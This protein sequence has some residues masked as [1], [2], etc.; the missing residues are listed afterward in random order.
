MLKNNILI[1]IRH[2]KRNK[3]F[4]LINIFGLALSMVACLQIF[5]YVS[6]EK[7]YD[8]YHEGA[9]RVY[10]IYRVAEGE[11]PDDGVASL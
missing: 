9:D 3:L 11:A 7:S 6:F 5:K 1:A 4:S 2:L 10:R 8:S